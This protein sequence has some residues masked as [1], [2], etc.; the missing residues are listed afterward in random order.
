MH[1]SCI[2]SRDKW[3]SSPEGCKQVSLIKALPHQSRIRTEL[4][5]LTSACV[6]MRLC[7]PKG[8]NLHVFLCPQSKITLCLLWQC[9][10]P[11]FHV[12]G[13]TYIISETCDYF[14]ISFVAFRPLSSNYESFKYKLLQINEQKCT[15]V[16]W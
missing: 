12:S 1:E 4:L 5:W 15:F 2:F 16:V 11:I 3:S 7:I 9:T 8:G 6:G 14:D 13:L 10:V